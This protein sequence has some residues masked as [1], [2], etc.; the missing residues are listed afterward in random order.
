MKRFDRTESEHIHCEDFAQ[1]FGVRPELKYSH[2][3]ASYAAVLGVLVQTPGLG[4]DAAQE[5]LPRIVG[6]DL[7]GNFHGHSRTTG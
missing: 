4:M 2:L 3:L 7:L 6:N 5:M 1:I